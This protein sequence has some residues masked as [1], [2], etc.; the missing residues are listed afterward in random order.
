M[1]SVARLPVPMHFFEDFV[2]SF[3]YDLLLFF[4]I[5]P[6]V[7]AKHNLFRHQVILSYGLTATHWEHPNPFNLILHTTHQQES[8]QC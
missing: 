6:A 3:A 2:Q 8:I 4:V 5:E 1:A 7:Y